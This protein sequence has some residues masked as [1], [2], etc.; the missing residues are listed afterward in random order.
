MGIVQ[1]NAKE[2]FGA[3]KKELLIKRRKLLQEKKTEEYKELVSDMIKKEEASFQDL[4]ME[5]IDHI[6]LSE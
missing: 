1:K 5:I 3:E 6:G 4:M 2:R